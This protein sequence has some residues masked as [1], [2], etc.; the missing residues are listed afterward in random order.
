MLFLSF[1]KVEQFVICSPKDDISWKMFHEMIGN[2]EEFNKSLGIPYRIVSIVS[3]T[4]F[5]NVRA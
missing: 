2:A 1:N 5:L 3:G 4:P